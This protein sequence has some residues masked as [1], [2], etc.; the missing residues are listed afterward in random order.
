MIGQWN[1]PDHEALS[2]EAEALGMIL[3]AY[4]L[5]HVNDVIG[6]TSSYSRCRVPDHFDNTRLDTI[7]FVQIL[8]K[9]VEPII[10]VPSTELAIRRDQVRH[11][12]QDR[13]F[14][15]IPQSLSILYDDF[16]TSSAYLSRRGG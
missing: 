14:A 1:D 16:R 11:C 3:R 5:C 10:A 6:D 2:S 13:H 4:G 12:T 8:Q 7:H 9:A 15:D